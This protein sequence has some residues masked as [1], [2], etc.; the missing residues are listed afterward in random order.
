MIGV[1]KQ[2]H[3][4]HAVKGNMSRF[5][6]LDL[7]DDDVRRAKQSGLTLEQVVRFMLENNYQGLWIIEKP[8][9]GRS[10]STRVKRTVFKDEK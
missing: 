2:L 6:D 1:Q 7:E 5:D 9:P 4:I 3:S 8:K 10:Q